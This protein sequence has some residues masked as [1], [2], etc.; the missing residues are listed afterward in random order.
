[1]V[2]EINFVN[3]NELEHPSIHIC[4]EFSKAYDEVAMKKFGIDKNRY[5]KGDW[6]RTEGVN[7][8]SIFDQVTLN[9]TQ[10]IR[11][12]QFEFVGDREDMTFDEKQIEKMKW[13]SIPYNHFGKC[14]GIQLDK[15]VHHLRAVTILSKMDSLIWVHHH[16][17][18]LSPD[19]KSKFE[20][21]TNNKCLFLNLS[22]GVFITKRNCGDYD[23]ETGFDFCT[24]KE[25]E[26]KLMENFKC[27]LPV[28]NSS[29]PICENNNH[30]M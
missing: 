7:E 28:S 19:V 26:R 4:P 20:I 3:S 29:N 13:R 2:T 30:S 10:I 14:Y 8:Y 25:A 23:N 22:Y 24:F 17:Q 12:I 27:V 15:H 6:P 11:A 9:I 1:M 18:M 5:K 21:I 16:G